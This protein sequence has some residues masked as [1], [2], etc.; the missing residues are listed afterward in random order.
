[1]LHEYLYFM[2]TTPILTVGYMSFALLTILSLFYFKLKK[3]ITTDPYPAI[4]NFH[5]FKRSELISMVVVTAGMTIKNFSTFDVKENKFTMNAIV[6]FEFNPTLISLE[7]VSAFSFENI[8]QYQ[9]L[10]SEPEIKRKGVLLF[11]KYNVQ[12]SFSSKFDRRLFPIG[13]HVLYIVL[14]NEEITV[15]DALFRIQ[16]SSFTS[17]PHLN[18][19]SYEIRDSSAQVGYE[20]SDFFV[21]S[22]KL[23]IRHPAIVFTLSLKR[24]GFRL[25]TLIFLPIL[26]ILSFGLFA[27][28]LPSTMIYS[29]AALAVSCI[30]GLLGYR[31]V[32]EGISPRVGYFTLTDYIYNTILFA[33]FITF[34]VDSM[35]VLSGG[36]T[37]IYIELRHV[38]YV[39]SY[40]ILIVVVYYYL[41]HWATWSH[42]KKEKIK[43]QKQ[44]KRLTQSFFFK[45]LYRPCN[46]GRLKQFASRLPEYPKPDD[47]NW[48][49]PNYESFYKSHKN[50]R[51]NF[52]NS[53]L[54]PALFK[55]LLL[56]LLDLLP[57][58]GEYVIKILP[59]E[60]SRII[61]I[62]D[63]HGAF[64][65]LVRELEELT[66]IGI[67]DDDLKLKSK[68]NYII[69]NGNV[70]DKSCYTLETL[71]LVMEL[72]KKNLGQVFYIRGD[73][74]TNS[75]WHSYQL[76]DELKYKIK[77][78]YI[79][80]VLAL[81]C[82]FAR[83]PLCV[84]LK[85]QDGGILR[86]SHDSGDASLPY[87]ERRFKRFLSAQNTQPVV[88]YP[89]DPAKEVT[90]GDDLKLSAVIIG[91]D[92]N[93]PEKMTTPLEILLPFKG[94]PVWTFF[95]SPTYVSKQLL[96]FHQDAFLILETP[97]QINRWTFTLYTQ[98]AEHPEGFK[99]N[100]FSL[101]YGMR[102][103]NPELI[104]TWDYEHEIR[105]G[106]SEDLSNI[107]SVFG[108]RV[109]LGLQVAI[110]LQNA[111]G[112][113]R[114]CP[115]KLICLDD[116]YTERYA[117]ENLNRLINEFHTDIILTPI[118]SPAVVGM[119]P[120]VK[121][122]KILILFPIAGAMEFRQPQLRYFIHYRPSFM[123]EV[124]ELIRF[125][126]EEKSLDHITLFYQEDKYGETVVAGAAEI[127]K[128]YPHVTWTKAPYNRFNLDVSEAAGI[129]KNFQPQ[130]IVFYATGFPAISLINK[131]GIE[132]VA[133]MSLFSVSFLTD[134]FGGFLKSM[135][136]NLYAS[137]VVPS[138]T[139]DKLPIIHEY[140][141]IMGK[142]GES[143]REESFEAYINASLFFLLLSMVEGPLTKENIVKAAES[144]KDVDFKGLHLNFNPNTRELSDKVWID[145]IA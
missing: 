116:R 120:E 80:Y 12:V 73:H 48:A 134:Q 51:L 57:L 19:P 125:A 20:E 72:I 68:N 118:G 82:F 53:P 136:L 47:N 102:F 34:L 114:N 2:T 65:S 92:R 143:Y 40:L 69:F 84:Y 49:N 11:V 133:N 106:S 91:A 37:R 38:W 29:S 9:L 10:K 131:L 26:I 123:R 103:K 15:S 113:I 62:S 85:S 75:L 89:F 79:S 105:V 129:I 36:D 18:T 3:F 1:M 97:K 126:I 33:A 30:T 8:I 70:V 121:S 88:Y 60:S 107:S 124:Q 39:L 71:M 94:V 87:D 119:L 115:I 141:H 117:K 32:I 17:S 132:T 127:F 64:H 145:F 98:D 7:Q 140:K 138:L 99:L 63:L 74:E 139:Q 130:G 142:L 77:K 135:G 109:V 6:W 59:T 24:Q 27:L 21:G 108:R 42:I 101:V 25:A 122:E 54:S 83:L 46:L 35:R 14:K 28:V 104:K 56:G 13:D 67:I 110:A 66:K 96:G 86:I 81:E 41:F 45:R 93:I 23:A 52:L 112:G 5:P 137:R 111:H 55:N 16:N 76:M 43:K 95:S 90:D 44:I 58:R 31:F 61:I 100:V 144:I 128:R 22:K 50:W 4:K 78:Q